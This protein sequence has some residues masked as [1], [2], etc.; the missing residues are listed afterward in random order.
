M[1]TLHGWRKKTGPHGSP[2]Q[3]VNGPVPTEGAERLLFQHPQIDP[4]FPG[5]NP[6]TFGPM[7]GQ[8]V[9]HWRARQ[10]LKWSIQTVLLAGIPATTGTFDINALTDVNG[11][12]YV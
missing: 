2:Y 4:V 12:P 5:G 11:R 10:P 6:A 8:F 9:R 1:M 3:Y 7:H